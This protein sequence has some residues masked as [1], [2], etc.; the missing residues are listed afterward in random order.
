MTFL[1]QDRRPSP[2]GM[3]AVVA[4]HAAA[5][6][7]IVTGLSVSGV[8]D[9]T[10]ITF[11]TRDFKDPPP[12][13]P[14]PPPPEPV[15]TA[16]A[17]PQD[18][19]AAIV[20][21]D[22]AF[23]LSRLEFDKIPVPD[24]PELPVSTLPGGSITLPGAGGTAKPVTTLI[25]PKPA[26]PANDRGSWLSQSD[27]KRAWT[28]AQMEGRAQYRLSIGTTG[29]VENCAIVSGTG[30]DALDRATCD[31]IGRRARFEPARNG[32]GKPVAG[33]YTGTV[34]WRLP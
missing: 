25:E 15:P 13:P 7:A 9:K 12:P 24:L 5:G 20:I 28:R 11:K 27:Y 18:T 10:P 1:N 2:T 21:P 14:P 23:D 22:P 6:I 17:K 30:H 32:D 29:R 19:R 8:I 3:V 34:E 26:R 4:L 16:Q 31:L 33:T